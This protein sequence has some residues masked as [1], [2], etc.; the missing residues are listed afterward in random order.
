MRIELT[1]YALPRRS[2]CDHLPEWHVTALSELDGEPIRP[3][4]YQPVNGGVNISRIA[5]ERGLGRTVA[6]IAPTRR[7]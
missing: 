3:K 7:D 2:P 1:A 4:M 6:D 5:D